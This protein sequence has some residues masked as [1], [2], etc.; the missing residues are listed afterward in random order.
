MVNIGSIKAFTAAI[1]RTPNYLVTNPV[2][3]DIQTKGIRYCPQVLEDVYVRTIPQKKSVQLIDNMAEK[4][5]ITPDNFETLSLSLYRD[6][7]KSGKDY[8]RT[9]AIKELVQKTGLS[10]AQFAQEMDNLATM[11]T[12]LKPT[13]LK[14]EEPHKIFDIMIGQTKAKVSYIAK[15]MSG[16][17]Y[18]IEISGAKPVAER[19]QKAKAAQKAFN[20]CGFEGDIDNFVGSQKEYNT[21]TTR[22]N[23]FTSAIYEKI[24]SI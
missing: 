24:F 17:V 1:K 23:D 3:K 6:I 22:F 12:L 7:Q 10:E 5:N 4:L 14:F 20:E 19:L 8:V 21:Y 18:K 2:V 13:S 15:G 11:I 9:D 16:S